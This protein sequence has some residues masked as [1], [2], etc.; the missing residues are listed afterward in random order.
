MCAP[1]LNP[2]DVTELFWFKLKD[3]QK[4]MTIVKDPRKQA[5]NGREEIVTAFLNELPAGLRDQVMEYVRY[6][7]EQE[8]GEVKVE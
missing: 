6:R 8:N 2:L 1:N 7:A 4:E 3:L 5:E